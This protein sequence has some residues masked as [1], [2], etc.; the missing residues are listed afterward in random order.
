M[1]AYSTNAPNTNR[2]Q[3]NIQT[4]MAVKPSAFGLFVVIALKIF[5]KTRKRVTSNVIRPGITSKGI[6]K[7]IQDTITKSPDGK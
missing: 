4:S 5:T 1:K 7:L 2:I 3:T 6:R